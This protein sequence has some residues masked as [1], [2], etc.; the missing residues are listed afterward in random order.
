MPLHLRDLVLTIKS[1]QPKILVLKAQSQFFNEGHQRDYT[2]KAEIHLE[3]NEFPEKILQSHI[4]GQF[5]EGHFTVHLQNR[6]DDS[7]YNLEVDLRHLPLSKIFSTL[8]EYGTATN[9]NPKQAWLSLKGRSRGFIDKI[10]SE[11]FEIKD[12]KLEGDIGEL[13]TELIEFSNLKPLKMR[14]FLMQAEELNLGKILSFYSLVQPSSTLGELG[15]FTGRVE[16]FNPNE[17]RLFGLHHGLEFIFSNLGQR[18]L[19]KVNQVSLD[20]SL[21]NKKWNL[22]L[23]R[24][25]LDQGRLDGDLSFTADQ[26]FQKAEMKVRTDD[27]T[28]SPD[29][30]SLITQGGRLGAIKGNLSFSWVRGELQKILGSAAVDEMVINSMKFEDAHWNFEPVTGPIASMKLKFQNLTIPQDFLKDS[31][32]ATLIQPQWLVDGNLNLNKVSGQMVFEREQKVQ[33]KSYQAFFSGAGE[34]ISSDGQWNDKGDL[35]GSLSLKSSQKTL[36]WKIDGTRDR[37]RLQEVE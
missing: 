20:G 34:K 19:Q 10:E 14:P 25:D 35:Q 3:Y 31:F 30:Q 17:V 13:Q 9:L 32:L 7:Q 11:S 1:A 24:F 37:P 21:K 4:L 18:Q 8:H 26:D 28:L 12:F 33:W 6:L 2:S 29:V 36:R 15:R 27:L 22:K 16:V 5:R 23:S